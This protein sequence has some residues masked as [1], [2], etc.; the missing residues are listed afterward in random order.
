MPVA[1][2]LGYGVVGAGVASMMTQTSQTL[3][4]KIGEGVELRYILVRH[5]Y[6]GSP[7]AHLMVRSFE[8]ILDDDEVSIVLEAMGGL[9]PAYSYAKAALVRGKSVVTSNKE[10]VAE[11]GDEL[12]AVALRHGVNFFFEASVGGGIP[13]IRPLHQCLAANRITEIAGILNGTTNYILTAMAREGKGFEQAL[14]EA[15]RLGYAEADPSADVDGIDSCRK[16]CILASLAFGSHIHPSRVATEGIR[17]VTREDIGYAAAFG[18]A[19]KLMGLAQRGEAGCYLT[20][21]PMLVPRAE[22]LSGIE[23]VFNGIQVR[24]DATGEVVFYGRGAGR[25]PTASAMVADLID[26]ARAG[27]T[28]RTLHWGPAD[29]TPLLSEPEG[30]VRCYLRVAGENAAASILSALPDA[31]LI[32]WA[33]APDG[34]AACV[35]APILPHQLAGG[36]AALAYRGGRIVGRMRVFDSQS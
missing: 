33:E 25:M 29:E 1:A 5:D 10:L 30:P 2:L 31:E 20:V 8:T 36:I 16:L 7:H 34:E 35:T 14:A 32:E 17:G 4:H 11:R 12:L 22:L 23:D 28:I 24:G 6:P 15:Q 19:V 3:A 27:G 9:E 21:Q 18:G 13:I 26:V